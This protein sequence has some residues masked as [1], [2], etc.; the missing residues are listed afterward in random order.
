MAKKQCNRD[1]DSSETRLD[2]TPAGMVMLLIAEAS[3]PAQSVPNQIRAVRRGL[4]ELRAML[5]RGGPS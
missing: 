1:A 5:L 4:V 2:L 3:R